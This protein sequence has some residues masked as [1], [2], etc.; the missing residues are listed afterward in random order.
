M[1]NEFSKMEIAGTYD[2]VKSYPCIPV[3]FDKDIVLIFR[4]YNLFI[5]RC[6]K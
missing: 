5:F 3:L 4:L 1:L 6:L 2:C